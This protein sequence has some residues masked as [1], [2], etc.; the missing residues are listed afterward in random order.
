MELKG[1]KIMGLDLYLYEVCKPEKIDENNE[2]LIFYNAFIEGEPCDTIKNNSLSMFKNE[3]Y[4]DTEKFIDKY[5]L[6]P[7]YIDLDLYIVSNND[8]EIKLTKEDI[9]DMVIEKETKYY[10]YYLGEREYQRKGLHAGWGSIIENCKYYDTN[11]E[12]KILVKEYGLDK[13]FLNSFV[14]GKTIFEAWW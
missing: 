11:T 2:F 5:K 8:K 12:V 13:N 6:N 14:K 3:K 10:V 7:D 4:L 1:V 9:E